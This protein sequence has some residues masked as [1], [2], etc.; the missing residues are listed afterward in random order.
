MSKIVREFNGL[1]DNFILLVILD[2]SNYHEVNLDILQ[3]FSNKKQMPGVYVSFNR[4]S[5]DIINNLVKNNIDVKKIFFIDCITHTVVN[6]PED[7]ENVLFVKSPQNLTDVGVAFSELAKSIKVADK[8][9]FFD[10]IS[11]LLVYHKSEQVMKFAHFIINKARMGGFK[12]I[13]ISL[14]RNDE[15]VLIKTVAQFCDKIIDLGG[16]KND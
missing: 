7:K 11:T 14:N 8:F 16:E 12:G 2:T 1:P 4:T 13:F 5:N 15:K 6:N 9:L 10:S 3:H